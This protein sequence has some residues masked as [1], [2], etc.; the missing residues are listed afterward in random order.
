M[1]TIIESLVVKLGLDT[2]ELKSKTPE[3]TKKLKEA[4]GS[5]KQF[6]D[7][8]DSTN[9]K[10]GELAA[11]F[12]KLLAAVGG[13][14]AIKSFAQNMIDSSAALDRFS[15]NINVNAGEITAWGNAAEQLGGS[16]KGVQSAM[17]LLSKAQTDIQQTGESSLTPYLN[18]LGISLADVN[19]HALKSTDILRQL[20]SAAEGKDRRTMANIFATMGF[21]EGTINLLLRGRNE[22]ELTLKRQK[23]YGEQAAKF[24]PEATKLQQSLVDIKQKFTL[25]GMSL[26]QSASP[27]IEKVLGMLEH[28][29]TWAT[30]NKD[31]IA[32]VLKVM[33][34]GF[35]A[36]GLAFAPIDL[37]VV[38]VAALGVAI[39]LLWNDYKVWKEGG[40]SLINWGQ[41]S[42]EINL[43][44][45]GIEELKRVAVTAFDAIK[46]AV[47]V[48]V[49]VVNKD[50]K[51]AKKDLAVGTVGMNKPWGIAGPDEGHDQ[52]AAKADR[53]VGKAVKLVKET[54]HSVTGQEAGFEVSQG[55]AGKA[56]Q[57][58]LLAYYMAHGKSKQEAA[59]LASNAWSES[60]GNPNAIGDNGAAFGLLQWHGDRQAAFKKKYGFDIRN[61]TWQQQADFQMFELS[62]QGAE[63]RAGA[64]MAKAT[65]AYDAAA[66]ESRESQRPG[67]TQAAKDK[68][69]AQ[70]GQLAQLLAGTPGATTMVAQAGS[71]PSS[72]TKTTDDH[73]ITITGD[74]N[75]QTQATDAPGIAQAFKQGMNGLLV[76]S[77]VAGL[78]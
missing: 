36:I 9:K 24:A 31:N 68:A 10:L 49:D 12:G 56:T 41:W 34:I 23:E 14:Y 27:A 7:T 38:G 47:K 71:A 73:R 43:A 29:A 48:G 5:V 51:A 11:G 28:F 60:S 75:I 55:K 52:N 57:A 22:L 17:Q 61:A 13:M 25:L 19:G 26:L 53:V 66:I 15:K 65:S 76:G 64:H 6:G 18:E 1:A 30:S 2:S 21:D 45:A 8:S 42:K 39:G 37:A 70:R 46:T 50:W 44:K 40:K 69:A 74:V 59:A 72:P 16:A 54:V 67:L 35:A 20:A 78:S 58:Q 63:H 4:E 77:A 62:S 3:A 33:A 32:D